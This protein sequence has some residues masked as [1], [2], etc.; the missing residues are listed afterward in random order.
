MR[1]RSSLLV[2]L[3]SAVACGYGCGRS[4]LGSPTGGRGTSGGGAGGTG[5]GIG[6]Q[7]GTGNVGGGCAPQPETCNGV[8]DDCD[9]SIDEGCS[10]V[11]GDV[12]PC[13]IG[14]CAGFQTCSGGVW[15]P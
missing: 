15:T 13:G 7:G 8:D 5:G 9:G 3:L 4:S 12:E 11:E 6:A 1:L 10:C 14:A 2:L